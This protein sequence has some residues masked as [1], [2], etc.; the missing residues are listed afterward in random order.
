MELRKRFRAFRE[1]SGNVAVMA[2]LGATVLIS[3]AGF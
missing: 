1:T 2:A 3:V